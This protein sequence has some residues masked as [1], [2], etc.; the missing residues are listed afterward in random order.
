[1]QLQFAYDLRWSPTVW[2]WV[3]SAGPPATHPTSGSEHHFTAKRRSGGTA[4]DKA[5]TQTPASVGCREGSFASRQRGDGNAISGV[6]TPGG[7][8]G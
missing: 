6:E 8:P 1:M 7:P 4:R 5:P 2:I 3:F